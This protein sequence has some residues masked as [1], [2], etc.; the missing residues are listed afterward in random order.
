[1]VYGK[2][3]TNE[4]VIDNSKSPR[5]PEGYMVMQGIR[6][7]VW[8]VAFSGG[9]WALPEKTMA[10][11]QAELTVF[12]QD[13]LDEW[14]QTRNY[15]NIQTLCNYAS[16]YE[17]NEKFR[18]EGRQGV[19]LRSLTWTRCYEVMNAVL[20]GGRDVPSSDELADELPELVWP[21]EGDGADG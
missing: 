19:L 11:V 18:A 4:Q 7:D 3:G 6:P 21:D 1:M 9:T 13:S 15:D 14:A 17:P 20:S 12:V 2:E 16:D 8:H 5:C 10:E